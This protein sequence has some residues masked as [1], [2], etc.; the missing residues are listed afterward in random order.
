[1]S[2]IV[3]TGGI[4]ANLLS[5]QGTA[6]MLERTQYRLATGRKVNT[7][8]DNPNNY[9]TS[10]ALSSRANDVASLLDTLGGAMKVIETADNG[11]K[12][13]VKLV[14]TAQATARQAKQTPAST[15][16][17]AGTVP[18]LTGA[19]AMTGWDVGDTLTVSDGTTTATFT[20]AAGNTVQN[21]ISAIN[22]SS[23]LSVRARL[24]DD[25]RLLLE[26][27]GANAIVVGG[28]ADAG[29]LAAIGLVAGTTPAAPV[30]VARQTF[31]QQYN[32]LMNQIDGLARDSAYNGINLLQSEAL[33]V[34]FNEDNSSSMTIRGVDFDSDGLGLADAGGQFQTETDVDAALAQLS[35]ALISL[36][37]QAT[38]LGSNLTVVQ[39]RENFMKQMI[40]TL[41][42]GA[43]ALVLADTNEEGA[44][45]LALQTRQQLSQTALSLATQAEQSVL[46][47]FG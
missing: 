16:T 14:E 40:N 38:T 27:R 37:S 15:A 12:G 47:L 9:F 4:R 42:T 44:N 22:A 41:R 5:L 3:L 13:L 2:D 24:S 18:N 29:E 46:R 25:G 36:R 35:S 26:A 20:F 32:E 7:A 28:T 45:M 1:M 21:A 33:R 43:D 10:S 6:D 39:M 19:S 30:S 34:T 11:I 23:N 17:V 8:L 31:A